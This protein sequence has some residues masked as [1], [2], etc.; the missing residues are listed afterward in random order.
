MLGSFECVKSG[1]EIK[2]SATNKTYLRVG[3]VQGNE[4]VSAEVD[5]DDLFN[6]IKD[7]ADYTKIIAVVDVKSGVWN[8]ARY[9]RHILK[10]FDIKK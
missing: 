1:T 7:L 2:T 8:G 3:L 6:R 4:L 9:V 5:N 10:G